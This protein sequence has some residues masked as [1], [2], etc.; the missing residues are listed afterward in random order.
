MN[1]VTRGRALRIVRTL[2]AEKRAIFQVPLAMRPAGWPYAY[3]SAG[4]IPEPDR[5]RTRAVLE[6]YIWRY[7]GV[8]NTNTINAIQN[9]AWF[10]LALLPQTFVSFLLGR[11]LH[12]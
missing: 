2:A 6:V 1:S 10:V 9:V 4:A 11:L 7:I 5:H 12:S 3:L 8:D